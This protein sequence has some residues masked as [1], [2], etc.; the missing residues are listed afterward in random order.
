MNCDKGDWEFTYW[1]QGLPLYQV[2]IWM[3]SLGDDIREVGKKLQGKPIVG[4]IGDWMVGTGSWIWDARMVLRDAN[5]DI[6]LAYCRV[7]Q[8]FQG[9]RIKDLLIEAVGHTR[10]LLDDPGRWLR[11]RVC[12]IFDL[13]HYARFSWDF[14]VYEFL[15]R[16]FPWILSIQRDPAN[17][18][19]WQLRGIATWLDGLLGNA[20]EYI[21]T[22]LQS[23]ASWIKSFRNDPW[24]FIKAMAQARSQ[25]I[26]DILTDP[27][28][29][30]IDIIADAFDLPPEFRQSP[31][32]YLLG[33]FIRLLDANKDVLER[34]IGYWGE[35]FMRWLWERK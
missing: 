4:G 31:T 33:A 20:D 29:L 5:A 27:V 23:M 30:I 12:D 1:A 34:V 22:M 3:F 8:W 25:F 16:Y 35:R 6:A 21:W 9:W 7:T 24:G 28:G 17:W 26:Y 15:N 2:T 19:A 32:S 10:E 14:T 13:P 11:E 18:V